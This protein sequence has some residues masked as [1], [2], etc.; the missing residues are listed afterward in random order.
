MLA[1]GAVRG[2]RRGV[3]VSRC[4]GRRFPFR[5]PITKR[6]PNQ[7]VADLLAFT[8]MGSSQLA[9]TLSRRICLST[10]SSHR[11]GQLS[12]VTAYATNCLRHCHPDRVC[13]LLI[14][15]DQG[16]FKNRESTECDGKARISNRPSYFQS[17]SP[18]SMS[19]GGDKNANPILRLI[20]SASIVFPPDQF[21]CFCSV[22]TASII[23]NLIGQC[24]N[25]VWFHRI[26]WV[27]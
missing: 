15:S 4:C 13:G 22:R 17:G 12:S 5:G 6:E 8:M 24:G 23:P 9:P 14:Y 7:S 2:A 18:D 3:M 26:T 16:I 11:T 27:A 10:A 20:V 1:R 25:G 19:V 21:L